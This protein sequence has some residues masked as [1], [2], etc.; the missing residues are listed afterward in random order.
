MYKEKQKYDDLIIMTQ[1]LLPLN[2]Y[3][4]KYISEKQFTF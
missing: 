1:Y 3:C 2:N 4:I